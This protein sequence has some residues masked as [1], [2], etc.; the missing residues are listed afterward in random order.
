MVAVPISGP[1]RMVVAGS[2]KYLASHP[3]PAKPRDLRDHRYINIRMPAAGTLYKW[4][5]AKGREDIEV[6]VDGN[7]IFDDADLIVDA[8]AAGLGDLLRVRGPRGAT[9]RDGHLALRPRRL[10]PAIP[11]LLPLLPRTAPGVYTRI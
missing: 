9:P 3:A 10:V 11:R 6:A 2:P 8:A 7:L 5:F 1:L 4:E